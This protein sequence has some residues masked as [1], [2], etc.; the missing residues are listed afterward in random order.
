MLWFR[1]AQYVA[2]PSGSNSSAAATQLG[3]SRRPVQ[4]D[5]QRMMELPAWATR[6]QPAWQAAHRGWL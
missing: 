5:V 4:R 3:L 1:E 2:T 6:M